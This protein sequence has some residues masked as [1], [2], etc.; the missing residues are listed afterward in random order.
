MILIR[1]ER[2][3]VER[4]EKCECLGVGADYLYD[5]I[6]IDVRRIFRGGEKRRIEDKCG[7]IFF[8]W[9]IV[10][11]LK[12]IKRKG[13]VEENNTR[14]IYGIVSYYSDDSSDI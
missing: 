7:I 13:K 11:Y 10:D 2:R 9:G 12:N 4:F 8:F 14:T 5:K 3:D 6:R 1:S